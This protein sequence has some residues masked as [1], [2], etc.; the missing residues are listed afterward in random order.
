MA[1][2]FLKVD[3]PVS[4][5]KS[6]SKFNGALV[7]GV[8]HGDASQCLERRLRS[9][10]RRRLRAG[11]AHCLGFDVVIS[12]GSLGYRLYP[13]WPYWGDNK[14]QTSRCRVTAVVGGVVRDLEGPM[15]PPEGVWRG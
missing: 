9:G 1:S 14:V 6:S 3:C 11:L 10:K 15:E 2:R 5:K 12:A 7:L 8:Q 4:T 13:Y